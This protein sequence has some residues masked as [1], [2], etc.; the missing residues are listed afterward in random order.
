MSDRPTHLYY[1]GDGAFLVGIPRRDLG[2]ADIAGLTDEQVAD[3]L[4]D[5][6]E[7]GKPLYRRAKPRAAG[8]AR[9]QPKSDGQK[10]EAP[11]QDEPVPAGK[12]GA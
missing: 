10:S 6:P 5:D 4:A 2:P 7:T 3:A 12:E 8:E 9:E 11:K 1:A